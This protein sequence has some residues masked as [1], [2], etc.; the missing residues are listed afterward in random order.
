MVPEMGLS[1]SRKSG[2]SLCSSFKAS[3]REGAEARWEGI[4]TP[5]SWDSLGRL[6]SSH[7]GLRAHSQ[8]G[9]PSRFGANHLPAPVVTKGDKEEPKQ[10]LAATRPVTAA[11]IAMAT[12]APDR[13][14]PLLRGGRGK[15]TCSACGG[16][17]ALQ[18]DLKAPEP[19][20]PCFKGRIR[21]PR[22]GG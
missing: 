7:S 22:E 13:Q 15:G 3:K 19:S 6:G 17:Q 20:L 18:Q 4:R 16:D 8:R 14:R 10:E 5:G 2:S 12:A 1:V 11:S 21:I 9:W